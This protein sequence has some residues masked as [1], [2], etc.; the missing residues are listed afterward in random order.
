MSTFAQKLVETAAAVT[1]FGANTA[2]Y[3]V[4]TDG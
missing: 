1:A 3:D 2:D 4:L